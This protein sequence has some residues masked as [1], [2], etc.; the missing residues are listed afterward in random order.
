MRF[1]YVIRYEDPHGEV[2]K[3]ADIELAKVHDEWKVV[4]IGLSRS[5][6][7]NEGI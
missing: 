1:D 3:H 6:N 4:R 5:E 2:V 7:E